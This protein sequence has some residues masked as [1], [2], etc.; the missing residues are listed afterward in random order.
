MKKVICIGLILGT[1]F[2]SAAED[3]EA[4]KKERLE[5]AKSMASSN[6][7][8][9]IQALQEMKS[10]IS[11][12]T[13]KESLKTCREQAKSKAESMR[14]ENKAKRKERMANRKK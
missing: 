4:K 6:I 2:V 1:G 8:K 7:D 5:M 13:D 14:A 11:S 9:R 12:A 3:K 10:C